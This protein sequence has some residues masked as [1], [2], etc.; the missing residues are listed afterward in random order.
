VA[1]PVT[2]MRLPAMLYEAEIYPRVAMLLSS[3]G[4]TIARRHST[5]SNTG[6]SNSNDR[7]ASRRSPVTSLIKPTR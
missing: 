4:N 3:A 6:I 5:P 2:A 7:M 1:L